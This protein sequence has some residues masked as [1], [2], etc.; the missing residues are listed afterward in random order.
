[1]EFTFTQVA[2]TGDL[3]TNSSGGVIIMAKGLDLIIVDDERSVCNLVSEIVDQFYTWGE[4]IPFVDV[5]KATDYCLD[6][7][8]GVGIF[9]V[10][11]FL[12][13]K[14]GFFFLDSIVEKFPNAHE[15]SIIITGNASNDIVDMCI[16]S[17]VNHLLEK[18]I[19]PYAL[20]LAVRSIAEKYLA[21]AK[22]LLHNPEFAKTV[23]LLDL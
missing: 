6:Q 19:K 23:S 14:S 9:I 13:Q 12:S 21:F 22:R 18:P 20:Q 16:A 4:I 17:N 7:D 3:F 5:E 15:D 11:V 10:D 8:V 2:A 1:M